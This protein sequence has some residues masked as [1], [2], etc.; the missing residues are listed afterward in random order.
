MTTYIRN[1][2]PLWHG[3]GRGA[4]LLAAHVAHPHPAQ[5]N[6][7]AQGKKTFTGVVPIDSAS[8]TTPTHP[9]ETNSGGPR[10]VATPATHA[11]D[12]DEEEEG[13]YT[14]ASPS[15]KLC[16]GAPEADNGA[17]ASPSVPLPHAMMPGDYGH[18]Y[19]HEQEQGEE[20]EGDDDWAADGANEWSPSALAAFDGDGE[21]EEE[22]GPIGGAEDEEALARMLMPPPSSASA[23]KGGS[24][25][26]GT[27]FF[28]LFV[29]ARSINDEVPRVVL[30]HPT[31]PQ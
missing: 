5:V 3:Q 28:L 7:R 10:R 17:Y 2:E 9:I 30:T 21:E 25:L 23:S 24:R 6:E 11:Q 19:Y 16:Y 4:P 15:L 20:G 14:H 27:L 18:G 31:K 13:H 8:A 1:R 22:E 12:D 26:S 29:V